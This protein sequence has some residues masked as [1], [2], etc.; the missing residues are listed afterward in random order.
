MKK[1]VIFAAFALFHYVTY[2]QHLDL[3]VGSV[4]T[5]LK[6]GAFNY[7]V[8]YAKDLIDT[9]NKQYNFSKG[10]LVILPEFNSQGGSKDAY[11]TVT[12]KVT[13]FLTHFKTTEIAG[14]QIP[15]LQRTFSVIPFAGGMETNSDVSF[16]NGIVEMGYFPWYWQP[17]S[18]G[19]NIL[20]YTKTAIFLQSGYKFRT[21]SSTNHTGGKT[22]NSRERVDRGILRS[23]FILEL[24]SKR[25]LTSKKNGTSIGLISAT[26]IWYDLLNSCFY[27]RLE[28][29][30][31]IYI[32]D[33][34]HADLKYEKGSGAPNFNTGDQFGASLGISF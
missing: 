22:D 17:Q 23:K 8:K 9:T 11:S 6:N 5:E 19:P 32:S 21:D 34:Y 31:R 14:L 33:Q 4:R 26:N 12:A 7:A 27:Y 3:N 20:K 30:A 2:A 15:D 18:K 16:V 24:D 1:T 10:F 28:A 13:G 29:K 25:L